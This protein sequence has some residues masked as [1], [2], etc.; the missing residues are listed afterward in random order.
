MK[1]LYSCV[2]HLS[3]DNG[4]NV[5]ETLFHAVNISNIV[6]LIQVMA[7]GTPNITQNFKYITS[8]SVHEH[9]EALIELQCSL[10]SSLFLSFAF[11]IVDSQNW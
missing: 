8:A 1:Q 11:C 5:C 9:R 3:F 2:I 6:L 7:F 4:K 10:R